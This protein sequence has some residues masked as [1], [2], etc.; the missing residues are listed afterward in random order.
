ME[1]GKSLIGLM[2][3]KEK[4]HWH[5]M[6]GLFYEMDDLGSKIISYPIIVILVSFFHYCF[7]S[8]HFLF[9]TYMFLFK[10]NQFLKN[11]EASHKKVN[12]A[13]TQM[14]PLLARV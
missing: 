10:K 13:I 12:K 8:M 6:N 7:A 3:K 1:T 11:M 4:V 9:E 5:R 14:A 2:L